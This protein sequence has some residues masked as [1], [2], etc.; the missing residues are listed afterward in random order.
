MRLSIE[1]KTLNIRLNPVEKLLSLHGSFSL[2]LASI[3]AASTGKGDWN[4]ASIRA[5]GTHIPF[6]LKAGTYHS[7]RGTEF[8]FATVGRTNLIMELSGLPYNRVILS[9]GR[10]QELAE[11]LNRFA[12]SD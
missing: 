2:P 12:A 5:P 7:M 10:A 6:L 9:T 8:W 1:G 11:A 3:T 4:F